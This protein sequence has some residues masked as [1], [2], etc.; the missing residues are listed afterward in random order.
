[1]KKI[2]FILFIFSFSVN[3]ETRHSFFE[4]VIGEEI[5]DNITIHSYGIS[6]E[7]WYI[8]KNFEKYYRSFHEFKVV[9]NENKIV[10][11]IIATNLESYNCMEK[12]MVA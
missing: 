1:M 12:N 4:I 11:K 5:P 3:A 6:N 7:E 9:R 10:E 8:P 2:I